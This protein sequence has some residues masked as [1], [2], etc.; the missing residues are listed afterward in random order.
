[1]GVR[2]AAKEFEVPKST[3][4]DLASG[5]TKHHLGRPTELSTEEE[6][7]IVE[8]L[9]LLST[10]GFPLGKHDLCF[11][12]QEYLNRLGRTTRWPDNLPGPDFV[13]GFMERH[14][15][16]TIRM[17]NPIKRSRAELSPEI[18]KD[19]FGRLVKISEGV[20][21]EN[22]LNYD[23]TNLQNNPG[24]KAAIFRKG[25]KYAEQVKDHG[26]E[27]VTVMF[28]GSASGVILPPYVIYKAKYMYDVWM[29][30]GPAGAVYAVSPS[31][32]I[33]QVLFIDWFKK[34]CL[35]YLKTLPGK[36]ILIGDNLHSHFSDEVLR[37][38]GRYNVEFICL[39]VNSTHKLQ[40]LD[41]GFFG[42][43]KRAWRKLLN[44]EKAKKQ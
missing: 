1:M 16:L 4:S 15:T 38:C 5:S 36:K 2:Q 40:P 9:I 13:R 32:W 18:I 35:P 41:V 23:E 25:V 14:K 19:F 21:P 3:L 37:L 44:E 12:V 30:N 28:C 8:R 10:W 31:G 6:L 11:L 17:S 22:I 39:P 27:A 26:K 20:P 34:I 29:L 43:M 7:L 33:D 24:A 42:P